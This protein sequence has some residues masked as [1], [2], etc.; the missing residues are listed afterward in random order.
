MACA[1]AAQARSSKAAART[2]SRTAPFCAKYASR[3][4]V[5]VRTVD[6]VFALARL[7][8]PLALLALA[9][10]ASA[11]VPAADIASGGPLTHVYVGNE[12]SCQVAHASDQ[13][14]ELFPPGATPASCGTLVSVGDAL[15]APDFANHD[16]SATG[17]L[18]SYTPFTAVSQSPVSGG[19][20]S[21]SPFSVTTVADAGATG[22]RITEVDTYV[23]G[24]EA[25]R[26]D[27]TIENRGGAP[28]NGVLYRAGDCYL[29]ESDTGYGFV[30]AGARAA[31]CSQNADNAPTG[32]IEQWYPITPGASYFEAGYSEVWTHIATRTPFPNTCR[33]T[34][35]IDNGA[36]LS[37]SYSLAPGARA[38][39]SHFTV[40]SP[41][42]VAGPP[43]PAAPASTRPPVFGANGVVSAPSNRRCISRRSFRIRIRQRRGI[44]VISAVV[45]VNGRQ[46][47]VLRGRRLTAPVNLRGLPRGR[48]TVTIRL[49]TAD[50][51]LI[52]GTR[53]YRT[54]APK[55]RRGRPPPV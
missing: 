41:T 11:A 47:R 42:G 36:G 35:P 53:R 5:R 23:A 14:R 30:D 31:G 28:L 50:G 6:G 12:L 15:Y 45:R 19:G 24:Q 40:F 1:G 38:T 26:T 44:R 16:G 10:P 49:F 46:V 51:R 32:R 7:A 13:A 34:E 43:P 4:R 9:A 18:G 52:T 8:P 29:Q 25:Y 20:T 22:L 33:C 27:V 39:F 3:A 17:G 2:A 55:R 54:C 21:A 48:Y 37:W